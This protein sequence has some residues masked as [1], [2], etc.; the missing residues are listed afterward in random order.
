MKTHYC[1]IVEAGPFVKI[2]YTMNIDKRF[3]SLQTACPYEVSMVCLFPYTTE[4]LAREMELD[5]HRKFK[6]FRVRGEWFTKAPVL[7]ELRKDG[8]RV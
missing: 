8:K 3:E 2:G 7:K 1:Y 4:E 6:K 5:L